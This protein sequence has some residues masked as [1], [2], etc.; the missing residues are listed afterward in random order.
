MG[1]KI[2]LCVIDQSDE[3]RA[4]VQYAAHYACLHKSSVGLLYTIEPA[5]FQE[6]RMVA[7]LIE[8]ETQTA[9][10]HAMQKWSLVIESL[11]GEKPVTFIRK[12]TLKEELLKLLAEQREISQLVLASAANAENP[13]PL[14]SALTTK[15]C[16][17]LQVPLTIVPG[18]LTDEQIAEII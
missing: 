16:S 10:Q 9:A 7:D 4:A 15:L 18:S 1:R 17:L 5:D 12:G 14:I 2:I 11:T 13:G 8:E 3:L 6:W